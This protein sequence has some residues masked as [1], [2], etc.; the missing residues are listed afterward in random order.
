MKI[1]LVEDE[2][3]A[4]NGICNM[5]RLHTRHEL[6]AVATNGERGCEE[7]RAHQPDLVITDIRMPKMS[8]LEMMRT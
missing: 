5:L 4:R 1:V 3:G 8:G 7:I 2:A 6:C